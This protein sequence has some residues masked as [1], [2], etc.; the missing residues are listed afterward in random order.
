M[1][2]KILSQPYEKQE[3]LNKAKH[4]IAFILDCIVEY[5]VDKNGEIIQGYETVIQKMQVRHEILEAKHRAL[6]KRLQ[7]QSKTYNTRI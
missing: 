7:T 5:V 1:L 6:L 3:V 4:D 2:L